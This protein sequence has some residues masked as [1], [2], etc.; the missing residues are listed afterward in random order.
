VILLT[1]SPRDAYGRF[2][3]RIEAPGR[4]PFRTSS[5]DEAAKRLAAFGVESPSRLV[6]HS[7]KWGSV[8][9]HEHGGPPEPPIADPPA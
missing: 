1:A 6:A 4:P 3:F 9:I 2:E 8:E 5:P 7:Q